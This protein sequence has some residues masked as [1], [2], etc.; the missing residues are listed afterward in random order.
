MFA[1]DL[2]DQM[3]IFRAAQRPSTKRATIKPKS[4]CLK[5]YILGD[6]ICLAGEGCTA[7]RAFGRWSCHQPEPQCGLKEARGVRPGQ[8]GESVKVCVAV[9]RHELQSSSKK[10]AGIFS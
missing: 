6:G 3:F 5:R 1:D 2:K 10:N 9:S 7:N 8:G 4:D